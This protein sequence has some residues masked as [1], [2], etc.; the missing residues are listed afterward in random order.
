MAV[1]GGHDQM[2]TTASYSVD[3][4]SAT[5]VLYAFVK[6]S[7]GSYYRVN[8]DNSNLTAWLPESSFS[9][10]EQNSNI[11]YYT[12]STCTNLSGHTYR[13]QTADDTSG[14]NA[15]TLSTGLTLYIIAITNPY[16]NVLSPV[17]LN[18][19]D[20]QVSG[21]TGIY[22]LRQER[23]GVI[24]GQESFQSSRKTKWFTVGDYEKDA[25]IRRIK[26]SYKSNK[27]FKVKIYADHS[28]T[29]T[30]TLEFES[31]ILKK[32]RRKKATLRAKIL[33]IEIETYY[34][35]SHLL[36]IYGMEIETDG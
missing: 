9:V 11:L 17:S 25:K 36:E 10:H 15:S 26:L 1:G 31:S 32:I 34:N 20:Y 3:N 8:R 12:D 35:A 30:H 28:T 33:Q 14:T 19:Y 29:P 27:P 2:Q 7:Q 16:A 23:E 5:T 22:R 21:G 24:G 6:S 13:I 4:F 18:P